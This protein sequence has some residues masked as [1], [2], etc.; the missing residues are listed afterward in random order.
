MNNDSRTP[1]REA[2]KRLQRGI[3]RLALAYHGQD[4]QL[5]GKLKQF[6]TLIRNDSGQEE[7]QQLIDSIVDAVIALHEAQPAIAKTGTKGDTELVQHFFSKLVVPDELTSQVEMSQVALG[8]ARDRD[9]RLAAVAAAAATL[10]VRLTQE[11]GTDA[12]LNRRILLEMLEQLPLSQALVRELGPVRRAVE[13]ATTEEQFLGCAQ[14]IVTLVTRLRAELQS[15][16]QNLR[17]YIRK[18]AERLAEFDGFVDRSVELSAE[19]SDDALQLSDTINLEIKTLRDTA[20]TS[21]NI[22]ELRSAIDDRLDNIG[23]GLTRFAEAQNDREAE[24]K[25][26]LETMNSKLRELETQTDS[27]RRDLEEQHERV[28]VDP[29]TGV[30]NRTGYNETSTKHF[31]RWKRY[32][33]QLSMAI[34]DLDHFKNINDDY[35]HAAGDRVLAT[36]ATRLQEKIRTSDVLCRYGGEEFVLI[37]PET[38]FEAAYDLVDK[39]RKDIAECQFR[40]KDTPVTVTFSSGIA[41]FRTGDTVDDVF[42]RADQAM[43]QAKAAGRDQIC[44]QQGPESPPDARLSAA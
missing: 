15:D 25:K 17:K 33:G 37:L 1:D 11:A 31:A 43:Y 19:A 18:I 34:I 41:Q 24:S 6:G 36:V 20:T 2:I 4:P 39:L 8:D 14:Q 40:H 5:D 27:L 9:E 23:A 21:D 42:E 10:S 35:G 22:D 7:R 32:G 28:L 29:L 26:A 3:L 44:A 38:D 30:M 16:V 12:A 13:K